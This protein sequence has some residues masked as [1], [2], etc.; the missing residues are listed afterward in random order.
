MTSEV[1]GTRLVVLGKQGAG[2]GTQAERLS[3]RFGLPRI[4][5]G[6]MFRASMDTGTAADDVRRSM[7][8]GDLVP[9]EVVVAMVAQRLALDDTQKAGFVLDG[10]PR[11]VAQAEALDR[12]LDPERVDLTIKLEVSTEMVLAR[13]AARRVCEQ[14]GANYITGWGPGV[15]QDWLCQ[16]CGGRV[17]ERIDDTH[18]AIARRLALYEEQTA[19]LVGWYSASNRLVAVD[20]TGPLNT[21]T[22][23][24]VQAIEDRLGV[25]S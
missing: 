10:F 21:V 18:A 11:T 1:S 16:V 3:L 20:G 17:V 4:S 19:P 6:E 13:L 2:K 12:I 8:A 23:R 15:D 9:D 14:C 22:A 24:L 25:R 5:T 7:E